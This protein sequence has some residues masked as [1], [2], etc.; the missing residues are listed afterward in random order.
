MKTMTKIVT[1]LFFVSA[2]LS[3]TS[4]KQDDEDMQ[5]L[6]IGDWKFVE[7][8]YKTD[9]SDNDPNDP[10]SWHWSDWIS[11]DEDDDIGNGL[12][13]VIRFAED[14]TCYVDGFQEETWIIM[15]GKITLGG[16]FQYDIDELTKKKLV[17]S[18]D[19]DA[20]GYSYNPRILTFKKI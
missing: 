13:E 8:Q 7:G 9:V 2:A 18:Y 5:K 10:Y 16:R 3:F 19:K 1:A 6:I 20:T 4:C 12:G 15:D 14:G 11:M 17:I